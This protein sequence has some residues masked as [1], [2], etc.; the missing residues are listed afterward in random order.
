MRM[1]Y[2]AV[3]ILTCFAPSGMK[4]EV[5][6]YY[7]LFPTFADGDRVDKNDPPLSLEITLD[8]RTSD[9][10]L[11]GNNG[12]APVTPYLGQKGATFLEYLD[13]GAVQTTTVKIDGLAV[14]S[15]HTIL[16]DTLTPSQ[17]YGRCAVKIS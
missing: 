13:S 5:I 9:A 17:Y 14:H 12:V 6:E 3:I 4:A 8:T 7:C 11:R 16:G 2:A 10:F 15:R 1:L